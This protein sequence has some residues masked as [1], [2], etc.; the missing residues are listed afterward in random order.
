V[1]FQYLV[2]SANI[3]DSSRVDIIT[4]DNF[5]AV[6]DQLKKEAKAGLGIEITIDSVRNRSSPEIASWLQQAKDLVKFC[7]LSR[8]QFILSSG[9]ESPDRQVSGQSLDAVLR[10]IGIEPQ[11]YWQELERWLDSRLALRVTRC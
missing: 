2:V 1:D 3:K 4:I 7:K 9:A 8:C 11:S 10:I 6:K 5:R